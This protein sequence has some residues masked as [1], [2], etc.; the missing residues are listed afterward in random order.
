MKKNYVVSEEEK[1][2]ILGLHESFKKNT[3]DLVVE[4][5]ETTS[6][7]G[8][9]ETTTDL[10]TTD[11][12]TTTDLSTTDTETVDDIM[13]DVKI[14]GDSEEQNSES[15]DG[16]GSGEIKVK[17]NLSKIQDAS[18]V[19]KLVDK[20]QKIQAPLVTSKSKVNL[21][22]NRIAAKRMS[23]KGFV[24][25]VKIN[26]YG[27]I[28]MNDGGTKMVGITFPVL[29]KNPKDGKYS[30]QNKLTYKFLL[31]KLR[32]G[33]EK[34]VANKKFRGYL[35]QVEVIHKDLN[36]ELSKIPQGDF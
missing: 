35:K 12:E 7:T 13:K 17:K 5:E 6:G 25:Q 34:V 19:R 9:T 30:I 14:V 24:G 29:M 1:N 27:S 22:K 3:I 10:S 33:D 18:E 15:G 8:S 21:F 2:R 26:G 16:D 31:N 28:I 23:R 4:Q 36:K 32:L 11:T 20:I